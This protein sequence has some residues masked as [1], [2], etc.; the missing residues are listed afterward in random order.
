[1]KRFS[2]ATQKEKK[3]RKR[4]KK[5][6]KKKRKKRREER[7]K[8]KDLSGSCQ[9]APRWPQGFSQY[10]PCCWV[11]AMKKRSIKKSVLERGRERLTWRGK[12]GREIL[13]FLFSI[14]FFFLCQL[15]S[16]LVDLPFSFWKAGWL[17]GSCEGGGLFVVLL[18]L[19]ACSF[20]YGSCS[21][22]SL[23]SGNGSS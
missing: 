3:K 11:F 7:R 17:K 1:M 4:K 2:G 15:S 23:L 19:L 14:S 8:K 20:A 16:G 6:R 18:Q 21:R 10:L 12:E 5:K 22:S 9:E 13:L